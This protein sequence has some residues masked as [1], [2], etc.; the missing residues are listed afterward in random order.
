MTESPRA[1]QLALVRA[2]VRRARPVPPEGVADV[3]PVARVAL[4]VSLPHLDRPFDYLVP[5]S[6]AEAAQPGVRVRARFAGKLVGGYVLE[7]VVGSEHQLSRIDRL[8][9]PEQVLSPEV[10]ALARLVADRYAGSMADVLRLA[11][12]A[13]HA[14]V[15]TAEPAP[16]AEGAVPPPNQDELE[17]GWGRYTA[18][19]AF[20]RSV[21][22]GH[23]PAAVW[24]ALPG[25]TWPDEIAGAVQVTLAAGRGALVVV[26]DQ[27]D[28]DRVSAAVERACGAGR[29]VALSAE[30]GP[31]ERYRR[32]LAVC[33]GTVRAVVGTRAAMFAPVVALG[34]A[35]VWDDGDDLHDEPHAPYP[36]VREVLALRAVTAGA[37]L[38]V[39]GFARTAEAQAMVESGAA[40][41]VE[42]ARAVVRAT[43]PQVRAAGDERDLAR[44]PAART[45]R[46][47][48]LAWETARAALETGP[49]LV[50]VPRRGYLPA[51]ACQDCRTPARCTACSGPLALRSGHAVP[52]CRWCGQGGGSWRCPACEST[53]LRAQVVGARRTAEELG[54][55]FPGVA[56]RTSGRDGVLDRVD[57]TPQVVVSTPGA[58]PTADGGYSAALLLDGWALLGR[59]DL[60]AGEEAL[61]RWLAAAALVRPGP[62]GGRVVVL[63]ESSLT[64]VQELVRWDPAGAAGRELA[65]RRQ[66]GF[67]PAVRLAAL[68]GSAA[69]VTEFLQALKLPP[70]ATVLGPQPTDSRTQPGRTDAPAVRALVRSPLAQADVLV[71]ALKAT[72][73]GRSAR[74][75][76][77]HVG[78]RVDPVDF[79]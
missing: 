35:V 63:A 23:G 40:H 12:P 21:A 71:A 45:A 13:R 39:G 51:L 24:T 8:V 17:A 72:Q 10:A 34:L 5:A 41:P 27:R 70:E 75:A 26:P 64:Q 14:R 78:V 6:M 79:G 9:S 74:K 58:E 67:P 42:A 20:L 77:E 65:D 38:L 29:H 19:R 16:A 69:A 25:A 22:A 30:L 1:E 37:G 53:R 76:R 55:A 44:D 54:R 57:G 15:E 52:H 62:A 73:A 59:A 43:A 3:L 7:R 28:L 49:V 47:P 66:L 36:H 2:T 60:R 46:L 33:R 4:D 56:V 50:Q 31:A 48:T 18:G 11:V 32:W 68:T 61:R